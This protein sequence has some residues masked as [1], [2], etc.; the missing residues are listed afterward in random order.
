MNYEWSRAGRRCGSG[1]GTAGLRGCGSSRSLSPPFRSCSTRMCLAIKSLGQ[2]VISEPRVRLRVRVRARPQQA[3]APQSQL[4]SRIRFPQTRTGRGQ[5]IHPTRSKPK[6]SNHPIRIHR[7]TGGQPD[8][9]HIPLI[10]SSNLNPN[11]NQPPS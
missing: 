1:S 3:P 6:L 7:S 11:P 8:R 4:S 9:P 10:P 2:L 5:T